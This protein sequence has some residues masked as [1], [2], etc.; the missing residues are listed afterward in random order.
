MSL[1]GQIERPPPFHALALWR[2]V[3]LICG[4]AFML[5]VGAMSVDKEPEIDSVA[6]TKPVGATGQI[7]K[8][9]VVHG[10][11]RY[12]TPNRAGIFGVLGK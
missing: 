7:C 1:R 11:I 8:V 2:R 9:E 6:P 4:L 10:S 3:V 12:V 5:V